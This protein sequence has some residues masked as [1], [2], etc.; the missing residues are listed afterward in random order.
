MATIQKLYSRQILDAKGNP[1]IETTTVLSDGST[2]TTSCPSG[3]SVSSYEAVDLL[4]DIKTEYF[5]LTVH[6]A[7]ENV[8]K[9]IAPKLSGMDASNQKSIDEAMI[10]LDDTPNKKTLGANAILSVSESVCKAAAKSSNISLYKYI[11][12]LSAQ[13]GKMNI[14]PPLFNIMNGGKHARNGLDFQEFLLIPRDATFSDALKTAVTI[15]K[16][17]AYVLETQNMETLVGDEGGFGPQN[18]HN[19]DALELLKEA[20]VKNNLSLGKQIF[21]GLDA[22]SSSFY[23]KEKKTYELKNKGAVLQKDL[24]AYYQELNQK[25]HF[26]YLEDPFAEDDWE[27]WIDITAQTE[28]NTLIVGDDLIST[29]KTRLQTAIEKKAITGVIIKP[30]QIGSVTETLDVVRLAKQNKL[31]VIVSHRSGETNDD[32]IADFAV[33]VSANYVKFGAPARGERVAKY[34]RLL[35]IEDELLSK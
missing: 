13:S 31:S 17:L 26:A 30:N 11:Q 5:G 22:A 3:T 27:A 8:K 6:K 35:Q 29:N 32:F 10:A 16:T 1:T 15:Y 12:A 33:G 24:T 34:N 18:I 2:G 25:Y 19:D 28:K 7:V 9:V 21:L 20:I 4:D 14:P 23:T